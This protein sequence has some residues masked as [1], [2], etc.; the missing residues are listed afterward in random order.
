MIQLINRF[1][2]KFNLHI[3]PLELNLDKEP[4]Y[5]YDE[6]IEYAKCSSDPAYFINNYIKINSY[7]GA[8]DFK[9]YPFQEKIVKR[10]S[11][12]R[13][14]ILKLARQSGK[15]SLPIYYLIH[16]IIFNNPRNI[17][18]I[19][20]HTYN[21]RYLL[22]FLKYSYEK[23]PEFLRS[24]V[25]NSQYN[26]FELENGTKILSLSSQNADRIMWTLRSNV[27]TDILIDELSEI[28]FET[29]KN[30]FDFLHTTAFSYSKLNLIV[31][32]TKKEG[33]YFN[34]LVNQIKCGN[35]NTNL[36]LSEYDWVVVPG[37]DNEWK[38]LMISRIGLNNFNE[39]FE[40]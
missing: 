31:T 16:Q 24:K 26:N 27:F 23:L 28:S 5:S 9:L 4:K 38:Q 7:S 19:S 22:D 1:L 8:S 20:N 39:E 34:D 35:Y 40:L 29:A 15:S 13:F 18:I 37:R 33:S 32:G 14:N 10:L 12:N 11:S 25:L 2:K 21:S 36:T 3:V 30:M 6:L 17:C